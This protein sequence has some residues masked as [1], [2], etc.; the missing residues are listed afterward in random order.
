[1][2][3]SIVLIRVLLVVGLT[4]CQIIAVG[5]GCLSFLPCV[6]FNARDTRPEIGSLVLPES[7]VPNEI[8]PHTALPPLG[9]SA[10]EEVWVSFADSLV[11]LLKSEAVRSCCRERLVDEHAIV[12]VGLLKLFFSVVIDIEVERR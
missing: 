3:R 2:L 11:D 8:V 6:K 10:E 7:L 12:L 5:R 1:V 9:L 4:G